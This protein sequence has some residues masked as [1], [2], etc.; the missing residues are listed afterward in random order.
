MP[1]SNKYL[2]K[3][4]YLAKKLLLTTVFSLDYQLNELLNLKK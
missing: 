2:A 4:Q 1:R 3:N